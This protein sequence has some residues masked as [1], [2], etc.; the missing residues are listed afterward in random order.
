ML[1]D[2]PRLDMALSVLYEDGTSNY[3]SGRFTC[4]LDNVRHGAF[5]Q[6]SSPQ[7]NGPM[8]NMNQLCKRVLLVHMD[9]LNI[10]TVS[11]RLI[12]Q[13][14]LRSDKCEYKLGDEMWRFFG[15]ADID[16]FFIKY[17]SIFDNIAQ[18]VKAAT[19]SSVMPDS[20]NELMSWAKKSE[21]KAPIN[22][23]TQLVRSCDWFH[24]AKDIRDS[25]EH[26]GAETAVNYNS[27]NVLFKISTLGSGL[28][29][30]PEKRMIEIP[31][32]MDEGGFLN[33][34]LF[35]GIYTGYLIWFL[36][37]VSGLIYKTVTPN[38]LDKQCRTS[39]P[40]FG[41]IRTWIRCATRL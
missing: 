23:Y 12:W 32:I 26:H 19:K 34:E 13:Q 4:L 41:T 1:I 27:D 20:F 8:L 2:K 15:S 31:E 17:R 37:E 33:F 10:A 40:G 5:A 39:H 38:E 6:Y 7:S 35:A 3:Y 11:V 36:E 21:D 29:G 14:L 25:I 28:T 24:D 30:L 22:E 9:L 18:T 16:L